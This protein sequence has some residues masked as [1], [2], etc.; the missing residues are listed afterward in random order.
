M[1]H[2]FKLLDQNIVLDVYSG[3]VH[4]LDDVAY[5]VLEC[6]GQ[7][8][9][10]DGKLPAKVR[11]LLLETYSW[12]QIQDA[13]DEL[14]TLKKE[15]LLY[16]PD[17]YAP[18]AAG[19]EKRSV[20]KAMCLHIAHD[21]NLRC[22]YCFASTGSFEGTRTMMSADV[23]KKAI[24]F[25]IANSGNRK[26]IEIDYFGGEP[27]M[28]FGV[29]EEIT[30]YA[31]R[32]GMEH[33]KHFRFTITTNG[34]L[35]DQAKM[36]YI[37]ENMSN[38]VLSID[39]TKQVND[40][41]RV[42]VD[43]SGSYD[44][45]VPKFLEVADSRGQDNYYVRG[46]FTAYNLDFA[47]D[48]LHLADLGF[49]QTSVEPVVADETDDYALKEE[50]LPQ[51]FSEYEKLAAEYVKR[52]KEGKGFN[53]FHFMIDL[54]QGP[55]VIK[56]LSGCGSGHEYVAVTPE[57][58]IYP[59]HQFVGNADFRMGSVLD[60]S[61]DEEIKNEFQKSNVYTKPACEACFAKFYCSGGC[62]ANAY[63]FN[64][65]INRPYEL[66]CEMERKRVECALAIA[67]SLSGQEPED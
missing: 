36:D 20:V 53:F 63:H 7:E 30:E 24:D 45:I 10:K 29:V 55:C 32:Q 56:R 23:G 25:V 57:G 6:L 66:A 2:S 67:A 64:R 34:L 61:F 51:I 49:L 18:Y 3:A 11:D 65:D 22:K 31:K 27:L 44:T 13:F 37:N 50:H 54:A 5:D 46:T 19:L 52:R 39:G 8:F 59:C 41:V 62:P 17:L 43:G 33:G 42:R 21:C 48:V 16:T 12:Q 60:G 1:I 4:I 9:P 15:G 28:N 38:I 14:S 40:R 26:N 58:D 47:K 35:L